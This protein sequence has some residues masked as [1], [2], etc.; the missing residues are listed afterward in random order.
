MCIFLFPFHMLE[1]CTFAHRYYLVYL[2]SIDCSQ[3]YLIVY[4][5]GCSLCYL[6]QNQ[7]VK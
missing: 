3:D 6:L 1:D 7:I 5:K 2:Q 4:P